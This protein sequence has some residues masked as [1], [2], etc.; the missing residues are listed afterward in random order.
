[1]KPESIW[2]SFV[3][4]ERGS[5]NFQFEGTSRQCDS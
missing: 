2:I 4:L 1:M 3:D 5:T